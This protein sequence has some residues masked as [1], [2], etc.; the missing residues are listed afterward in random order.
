MVLFCF[1]AGQKRRSHRN[2]PASIIIDIAISRH[3]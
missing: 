3:Y 1:A 2:Q